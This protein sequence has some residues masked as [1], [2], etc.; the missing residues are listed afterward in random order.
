MSFEKVHQIQPDVYIF[1]STIPVPSR[2]GSEFKFVEVVG[3]K[4][5]YEGDGK[6][7]N[8]VDVFQPDSCN[9]FIYKLRSESWGG[10]VINFFSRPF[11]EVVRKII[12]KFIEITY[13]RAV[14]DVL[15]DWR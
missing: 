4:L 15:K 14:E 3:G 2:P 13:N 7:D 5:E 6:Q 11:T 12:V 8:R 9:F 1:K 10:K